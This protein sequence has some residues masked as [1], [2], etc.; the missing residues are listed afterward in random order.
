MRTVLFILI[1]ISSCRVASGQAFRLNEEDG[2]SPLPEPA[3]GSAEEGLRNARRAIAKEAWDQA[4]TICR[5]WLARFTSTAQIRPLLGDQDVPVVEVEQAQSPLVGDVRLL[6]G[7]ALRARGELYPAAVEYETVARTYPDSPAWLDAVERCYEIAVIWANK[8]PEFLLGI[9]PVSDWT[10]EVEELLIRVQERVPGS[11]LAE[12]AG[13]ALMEFYF[14]NE[15][16]RLTADMA[17]IVLENHP[18]TPQADLARRR[19]VD[20]N[21]RLWKG[22]ENDLSGLEEASSILSYFIAEDPVAAQRIDSAQQLREVQEDLV[23][24]QWLTAKWYLRSG[25][26]VSAAYEVSRLSDR[27]S[28]TA[29]WPE[30]KAWATE[31]VR[32]LIPIPLRSLVDELP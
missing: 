22:P 9:F 16:Y 27:F 24:S 31:K 4:E 25:D 17:A 30:I 10:E 21:R 28:D 12:R 13:F 11:I 6:L 29:L 32:P 7:D 14:R 8:E 1:L 18:T 20:A 15:N 3:A 19:I 23:Q 26:P 2:W 5:D